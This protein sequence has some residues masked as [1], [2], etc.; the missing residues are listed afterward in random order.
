MCLEGDGS[1]IDQSNSFLNLSA[2]GNWIALLSKDSTVI[3]Q[4]IFTGESN[5]IEWPV[6]RTADQLSLSISHTMP[7]LII[8][9]ET[10]GNVLFFMI[11]RGGMGHTGFGE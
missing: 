3:D 7:F 2:S 1:W 5:K 11:Q 6:V 8:S 4:V 10:G 9:E